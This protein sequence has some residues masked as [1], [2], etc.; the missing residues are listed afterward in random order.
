MSG[1]GGKSLF[2]A[3]QHDGTYFVVGFEDIQRP[4]RS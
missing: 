1:A 2:A 4:A 3:G